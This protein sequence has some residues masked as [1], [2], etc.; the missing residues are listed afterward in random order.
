MEFSKDNQL[1]ACGTTESYIRVWSLD[2]V[3]PLK[4]IV[5]RG[6]NDPPE[7]AS[8]RLIGHSGPVYGLSWSPSTSR[9][10]PVEDLKDFSTK[11]TYLLSCSGDHTIRLWSTDTWSCLCVYKGHAAPVWDIQ[12]GPY[13]HYFLSGGLDKTARVWSVDH[14]SALRIFAGHDDDVAQVCYHPNSAYVFTGSDDK[15][16][17]MWSFTTGNPV[18]LFTGIVGHVT[19]MSCSRSG[20]YLA[21]GTDDGLI[22]L[23]D[24]TSGRRLKIMRGHGKGGIWSLSWSV[25]SSVLVSGGADC[26]VR[27]W[28]IGVIKDGQVVQGKVIAEGGAGSRIADSL[29]VNAEA[30]PSKSKPGAK[31][32]KG[33]EV[34]ISADQVHAFPTKKSPVYKVQFTDQNLVIAG[35]AFNPNTAP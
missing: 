7:T 24:L 26:T 8:R 25:E 4:S 9:E 16:V 32:G 28:D 5:P 22:Y 27:L 3:T 35:G 34:V 17:R 30:E 15:T 33:K 19:A 18:R 13:G 11:P 14:I 21:V 23:F 2:G 10:N 1:V 20:K 29:V 6:P 12:W 31:K